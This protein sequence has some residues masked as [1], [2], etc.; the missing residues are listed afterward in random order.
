MTQNRLSELE[1]LRWENSVLREKNWASGRKLKHS[2]WFFLVNSRHKPSDGNPGLELSVEFCDM[3]MKEFSEQVKEGQI[4]TLNRKKHQ[5]NPEFIR[6]VKIRYVNEV[7]K[8]KLKKNGQPGKSG[9]CIHIHCLLTIHHTSNVSLT[10]ESLN[11]FFQPR[12]LELFGK[13]PFVSHPKL[14][15]QNRVEEYMEKGF[16]TAEWQ[17]IEL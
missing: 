4:V 16:E 13:N 7:G 2:E 17:Q 5:W 9:G 15:P 10:W 11:D 14:I 1:R 8:G 6:S 3:L 12:M